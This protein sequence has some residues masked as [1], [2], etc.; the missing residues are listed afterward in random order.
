MPIDNNQIFAKASAQQIDANEIK[1]LIREDGASRLYAVQGAAIGGHIQLVKDLIDDVK[2]DNEKKEMINDALVGAAK[3]GNQKLVE[4]LMNTYNADPIYAAHGAA[5]GARKADLQAYIEYVEYNDNS[6]DKNKKGE[7]MRQAIY[8]AAFEGHKNLVQ[9]LIIQ[10]ADEK[11]F[12]ETEGNKIAH[13]A[14]KNS[15]KFEEEHQ[16]ERKARIKKTAKI[17]GIAALAILAV[18]LITFAV[19]ASGGVLGA[20]IGVGVGIGAGTLVATGTFT[21]VTA[22]VGGTILGLGGVGA[23]AAVGIHKSKYR[24]AMKSIKKKVAEGDD[25]DLPKDK[26]A[27]APPV[28]NIVDNQAEKKRKSIKDIFTSMTD[29]LKKYKNKEFSPPAKHASLPNN[30]NNIQVKPEKMKKK[31][32]FFLPSF[33]KRKKVDDTSIE[34]HD[35]KKHK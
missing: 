33:L 14:E 34:M 20:I 31:F 15:P 32:N 4:L 19:L 16:A 10:A 25:I 9:E 5:L 17:V 8:G 29:I 24:K 30:Q 12:A 27:T 11:L 35:I 18:G 13:H 21:T 22:A 1:R 23:V 2:D 6:P 3:V 26:T 28:T 7:A